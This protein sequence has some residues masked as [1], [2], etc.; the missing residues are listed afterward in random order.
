[1][2]SLLINFVVAI[3]KALLPSLL[4]RKPDTC[5][6]AQKQPELK[7]RLQDRVRAK[8][9]ALVVLLALSCVAAGGAGC[10][11]YRTV[12]IPPGEPVRL[13]EPLKDVKIWTKDKDGNNIP[14]KVDIPEGW[15]CLP[16]DGISDCDSG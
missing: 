11:Q 4:Q 13:R 16:D 2:L 5:D 12:Y 1:M 14:G 6:D 9:G 15:Y 8:F 3:L 7:K 10:T